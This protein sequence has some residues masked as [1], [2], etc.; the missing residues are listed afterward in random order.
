M[1]GERMLRVAGAMLS[2]NML[3][4]RLKGFADHLMN[5][6]IDGMSNAGI[7]RYKSSKN[8]AAASFR[9]GPIQQRPDVLR[10]LRRGGLPEASTNF[11]TPASGF[12]VHLRRRLVRIESGRKARKP[13]HASH[14]QANLRRVLVAGVSEIRNGM[15]D[16]QQGHHGDGKLSGAVVAAEVLG[17]RTSVVDRL[18]EQRKQPVCERKKSWNSEESAPDDGPRSGAL[19]SDIQRISG[20]TGPRRNGFVC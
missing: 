9:R 19:R 17:R 4:S 8:R 2:V 3:E 13:A 10:R 16:V 7:R 6:M 1:K 12:H 18:D 14:V 5:H 11:R 20:G 15:G